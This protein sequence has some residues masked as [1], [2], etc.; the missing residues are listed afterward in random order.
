[1]L[2]IDNAQGLL[3]MGQA[4][5]PQLAEMNIEPDGKAHQFELPDAEGGTESAWI[6][7]TDSA[8]ALS[9]SEDGDMVLPSLLKAESGA[10]PPFMSVGVDAERYYKML[11]EAMRESDD[12]EMPEEMRDALAE[13]I[14]VAADF[15]ERLQI[16]VTFTD[17]GIEIDTDMSLAD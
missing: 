3:A 10:P 8:I 4:M 17:R 5:V 12:E 1:L 16:D 6:A 15:Y 7:L 11:G 9:V 13:I 2:A 14:D